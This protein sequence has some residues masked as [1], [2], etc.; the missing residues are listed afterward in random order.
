[1]KENKE[2]P[3]QQQMSRDLAEKVMG[4]RYL[5]ERQ[6]ENEVRYKRLAV[7]SDYAGFQVERIGQEITGWNPFTSR[8]DCAE[9]LGRLTDIQWERLDAQFDNL[10]YSLESGTYP[11][12]PPIRRFLTATPAQIAEAIWRATC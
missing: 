3:T 7:F 10:V 11:L 9:L 6:W 4:W 2:N 8:D 1:M 12:N 5:T